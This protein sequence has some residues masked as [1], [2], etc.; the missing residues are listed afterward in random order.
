MIPGLKIFDAVLDIHVGVPV[1]VTVVTKFACVVGCVVGVTGVTALGCSV[2]GLS[3]PS[4]IDEN[5]N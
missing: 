5:E 3:V 2:T 1:G 4:L